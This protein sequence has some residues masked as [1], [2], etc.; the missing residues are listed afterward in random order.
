[1]K[2]KILVIGSDGYLGNYLISSFVKESYIVDKF[3]INPR[4]HGTKKLDV[5]NTNDVVK[6]LKN[7]F[8]D[9]VICLVGCLEI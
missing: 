8:Y 4:F 5:K 6:I 9:V 3:D 2:K 7:N 1:M